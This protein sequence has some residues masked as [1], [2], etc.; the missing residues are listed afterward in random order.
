VWQIRTVYYDGGPACQVWNALFYPIPSLDMPVLGIDLLQFNGKKHLTVIDA[1]PLHEM[2]DLGKH[3]VDLTQTLD[4]IIA[5]YPK[6]V[7][8]MRSQF[9]ISA[10]FF[11]KSTSARAK[12]AYE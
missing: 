3:G 7:G 10:K 5:K 2:A 11:S 6:L 1:Q 8:E 4:E 12:C 9:Y